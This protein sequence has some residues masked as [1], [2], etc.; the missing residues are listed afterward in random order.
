MKQTSKMM[1]LL[2]AVLAVILLAGCGP[3]AEVPPTEVTEATEP[4]P[5]TPP[6]GNP[7]DATCLGSYTVSSSEAKNA[8]GTVVASIGDAKLT[9]GLL[10]IYYWLEVA[11]YRLSDADSQPDYTQALS[12]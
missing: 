11:A 12:T 1:R 8:A 4:V 9:N 2:C 6:N 10:Q 3:K 7:N 5:T